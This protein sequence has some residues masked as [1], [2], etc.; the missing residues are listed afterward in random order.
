MFGIK[1][2]YRVVGIN[3]ST[4]TGSIV[5]NRAVA[6][7]NAPITKNAPRDVLKNTFHVTVSLIHLR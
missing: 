1:A 6:G 5:V 2:R 4:S 7:K 3:S